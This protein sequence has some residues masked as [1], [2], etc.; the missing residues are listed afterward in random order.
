MGHALL[1]HADIGADEMQR[2]EVADHSGREPGVVPG[3]NL[4]G[5]QIRGNQHR[6]V[7]QNPVVDDLKELVVGKGRLVLGAEIVDDQQV[8]V[9][10]AVG[11]GSCG[12]PEPYKQLQ[13]MSR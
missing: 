8:A 2:L 7:S 11:Q 10:Q 4:L 13:Q 9:R 3:L 5:R 1:D 12:F 6:A